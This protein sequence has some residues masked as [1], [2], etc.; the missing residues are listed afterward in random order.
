MGARV[1][2]LT[3]ARIDVCALANNHVLDYGYPG[4]E[5]TLA[6]LTAVGVK[7][8]GAGRNLAEAQRP[9]IVERPGGQ[10][11]IVFSFGTGT[12]GIPPAWAAT[13]ERP[14]V[15]VLEDLSDATAGRV[16]ERVGRA[17]RPG[18]LVV[19]SIH[20]GGN[21]GYEVPRAGPF[22]SWVEMA[23]DGDLCLRWRQRGDRG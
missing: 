6:T 22:G 17:K 19:A 4:L 21:W 1:T 10:R 3:A 16:V 8:A 11:V 5:E 15:D 20:W 12:S 7:T 14:G 2:L 18:D 9:A 13:G 23:A